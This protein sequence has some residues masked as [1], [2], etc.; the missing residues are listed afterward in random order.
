MVFGFI[1][2]SYT[3]VKSALT[4]ARS[5]LSQKIHAIFK[6]EL[7]EETLEQLEQLLYEADFGVKTSM[8]LTNKIRELHR[9]NPHFKTDDYLSAL[10]LE[11]LN[12]L[13]K[14][15]SQLTPIDKTNLPHV[16]LIV[17]VNGNGKT[18][19]VAKLAHLFQQ[20][21]QK[22]LI[23]GADTFRAAAMEQL[24]IW[25]HRLQIDLV[26]GNP[27]SDP[28]AVAFDA[29]QAGKARQCD[30]V[31]IDTAGR[32]HTKTPLMQELEKIKRSC[33]K[34]SPKA[35]HE[36]LL[37]LDATTGQNAID[38]AKVFCQFTPITGL[39]LTKLDGTAKGGIILAIQRELSI[40]VK[41]IGVGEGLEDIQ[42][43]DAESFV[44]NLLE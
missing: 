30:V 43:F 15:P 6:G 26:R 3:K 20:N 25:A 13:N 19:S 35:P 42:P 22:V 21:G 34:L 5:F 29:I 9:I 12:M 17:G 18:T 23:G 32:L 7:N 40:P 1:K 2:S 31:I 4:R 16:I 41:F 28:A 44:V 39:I 27:K 8:E 33:K 37:V 11:I 14:T 24:E 10:R 36:T 38:Q